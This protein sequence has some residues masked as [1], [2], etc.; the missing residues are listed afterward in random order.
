MAVAPAE[1]EAQLDAD[2]DAHIDDWMDELARLCGQPS[3]SARHEGIDACAGLV[4]ALL[5]AR[6]LDAE[7]SPT[8]GGHPVVLAHSRGTRTRTLLFYN[9]Y[10]VQPPEPLDLW[11]SAPFEPVLRG[12]ANLVPN[13]PWRLIWALASLK[14]PE[15]RIRI[16]G[17][18]D[19][20]KAPSERQ[21]DLLARL[22]SHEESIKKVYGIERLLLNRTG[23]EVVAA[24]FEP[25]CNVAGIGSGYLG[26]GSK[27]IVPAHAMAKVDFRLVPD[28]DPHDIAAKLRRHL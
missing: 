6:G 16:P 22:P 21:R 13:A 23:Q 2:I 25:T 4:A 28:Q 19:A 20:V 9:H 5:R 12:G 3:V 15:E 27:T 8:D 14:G 1:A 11:H 10:D 26:E 7:V 24:P 17:F 18:Y